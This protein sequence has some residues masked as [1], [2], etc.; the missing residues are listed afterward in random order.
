MNRKRRIRIVQ[1]LHADFVAGGAS[2]RGRVR[3]VS[4]G[5]FFVRSPL[6]PRPG[7]RVAVALKTPSGARI[8]VEGVVR[9]T[10]SRTAAEPPVAGFGVRVLRCGKEYFGFVDGALAAGKNLQASR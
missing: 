4:L 2:G 9:W 6:L 8:A 3:D 1:P 7:A 5:G 10:T